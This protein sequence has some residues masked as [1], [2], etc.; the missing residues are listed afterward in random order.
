[1]G[2]GLDRQPA[3]M[4]PRPRRATGINATVPQKEGLKALSR[5]SQAVVCNLTRAHQIAN[6][7][8]RFIWHP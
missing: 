4:H 2:E 8:M 1:M 3:V 6:G 7:F 5:F